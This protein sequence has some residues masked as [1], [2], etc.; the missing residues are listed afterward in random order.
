[1]GS[2]WIDCELGDLIELKRGYDLPK[3]KRVNGGVPVVSSL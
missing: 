2:D 3:T 1:M